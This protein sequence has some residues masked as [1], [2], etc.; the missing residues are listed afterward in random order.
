MLLGKTANM[1]IEHSF[2]V[3]KQL[4]FDGKNKPKVHIHS[5]MNAAR[6]GEYTVRMIRYEIDGEIFSNH[7]ITGFPAYKK[8]DIKEWF[9][10]IR[11]LDEPFE[12]T[13]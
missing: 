9:E 7:F 10:I 5:V 11:K 3:T 1:F 6:G 13:K 4:I 12:F 8:Q 2:D